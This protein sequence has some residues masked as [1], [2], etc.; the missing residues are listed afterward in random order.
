MAD[1]MTCEER[2]A[3]RARCEAATPG[4]WVRWEGH[5]SVHAGL[6]GQNTPFCIGADL[7]ICEGDDWDY[8]E[9]ASY[10]CP[11]SDADTDAAFI[12]AARTDLPKALDT[13]DALEA[14]LGT[15]CDS[16]DEAADAAR[17]Y[18][19]CNCEQCH[20]LDDVANGL[21]SLLR[22]LQTGGA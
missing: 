14:Q 2:S 12:A 9:A 4:P 20:T 13:I 17:C 15:L 16:L 11:V 8:E 6:H 1:L 3:A 19:G 10:D 21:R 7:R 22:S 18:D 5:A